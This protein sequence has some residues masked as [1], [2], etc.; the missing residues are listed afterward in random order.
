MANGNGSPHKATALTGDFQNH[1]RGPIAQAPKR[2]RSLEDL[3]HGSGPPLTTRQLAQI[4]GMS[5][6]FIREEIRS[7]H[8]RAVAVG[9]GRKRVFRILVREAGRYAKALGL[10]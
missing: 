1:P 9:R 8:L 2:I 5:P 10:L 6:T 7:G 3:S 4:I